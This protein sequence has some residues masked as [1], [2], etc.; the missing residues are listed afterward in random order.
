[1]A[2]AHVRPLSRRPIWLTSAGALHEPG[3]RGML[4]L[5]CREL[6]K[7][8]LKCSKR[9]G[10]GTMP[11]YPYEQLNPESFQQLCQSMLVREFQGLQAFPV[12]QPDG[13]RDA[14]FRFH[15]TSPRSSAFVLFQVKFTRRHRDPSDAYEW[16][17]KTLRSELPKIERQI[18]EGA[19]R[20][21]LIT[22]VPGTAH[23]KG[24]TKDKLQEQLEE[25]IPIPASAW[26]RDDLDR[27]LDDAWDLKLAYPALFTGADFLRLLIEAGP[28]DGRERRQYA[29]SA[30]LSDQFDSDREVKFKQV[31]LEND[32][33]ELFTDVPMIPQPRSG[34]TPDEIE[35]LV[36]TFR[37]A[38]GESS[39]DI[40]PF[41]LH[42]WLERL[43][44]RS[45]VVPT[46][47][48]YDLADGPRPGAASSPA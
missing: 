37:R 32:V 30:F 2:R 11:S 47:E 22:N 15:R 14:I 21:L 41:S 4:A 27:R 31:E 28:S 42:H 5:P 3:L 38:S 36:A 1:M 12:G 35:R 43:V 16:L 10:D 45:R 46:T 24:G 33:F 6:E 8:P 48:N 29:L 23:P 19:E 40:D 34:R 25:I 26:W 7:E 17:L 18:E 39:G 20:F 44:N 13:G 9:T